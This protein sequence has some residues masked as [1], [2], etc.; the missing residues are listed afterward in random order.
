MLITISQ[1]ISLL[2]ISTT[3]SIHLSF[4]PPLLPSTIP[5]THHCFHP[6]L[7][8]P[9]T[10]SIHHSFHP[11]LLPSTTPST[12][13]S[14]HPPLFPSCTPACHLF[15]CLFIPC[16]LFLLFSNHYYDYAFLRDPVLVETVKSLL[17]YGIAKFDFQM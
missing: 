8:P 17:N 10:P 12:H 5:S 13:H 4:L 2:T 11:P 1:C 3:P 6:P 14:F 9:T 16:F 15:V 7:L